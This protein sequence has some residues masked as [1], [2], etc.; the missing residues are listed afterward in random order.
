[1]NFKSKEKGGNERRRKI[2]LLPTAASVASGGGVEK[3]G[4]LF[5]FGWLGSFERTILSH[6]K[7]E[8][9]MSH[10]LEFGY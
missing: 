10:V 4:K 5:F 2:P 7:E 6:A 8:H 9:F 1:M 3:G